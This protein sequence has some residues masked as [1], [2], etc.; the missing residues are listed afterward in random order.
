ME[1]NVMNIHF[2]ISSM[3]KN[4]FTALFVTLTTRKLCTLGAEVLHTHTHTPHTPCNMKTT[5]HFQ[6][7]SQVVYGD[8]LTKDIFILSSQDQFIISTAFEQDALAAQ[9]QHADSK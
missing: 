8:R 1:K 9:H 6:I 5:P 7:A 2:A 3:Q 4:S